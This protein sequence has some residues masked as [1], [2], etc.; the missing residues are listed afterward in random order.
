MKRICLAATACLALAACS[1]PTARNQKPGDSAMAATDK[2]ASLRK[3]LNNIVAQTDG[4][5]G[6]AILNLDT[7]DTITLNDTA[8]FPMQSTFKFPIA[9]AVLKQVDEGKLQLDQ[10][11]FI[12]KRSY[13]KTW[14]PLQDSIPEGN[15]NVPLSRLISLM[16]S[17]SDNVACDVLLKLIG[18]EAVANDYIHSLG[19]TDIAI[20]AG[21]QKMHAAWDVQFANWCRPSAYTQLLD[22]L[23]K[24]TALS[25][26]SNN[27]LL[28][29]MYGTTTGPDRIRGLLPKNVQVA[30]KTGTSGV[31]NGLAAATNDVGFIVLPNGQKL[32]VAVFVSLSHADEP[33]RDKVIAQIA[34]A[35]YDHAFSG[36]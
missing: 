19:V 8:H 4:K 31:Q 11:V 14:S 22:I 10:P 27:F 7:R 32:A 1:S 30:H 18:G 33:T 36:N 2:T 25:K 6:V 34:K 29:V 26:T 13:F 21:E 15:A 12:D 23:N 28:G 35:A 9:M 20:V 16:V 5:V 3:T 24:G 17:Q